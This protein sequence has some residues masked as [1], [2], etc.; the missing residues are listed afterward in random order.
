MQHMVKPYNTFE[1]YK[2]WLATDNNW[3]FYKQAD[4]SFMTPRTEILEVMDIKDGDNILEVGCANGKT[5]KV[6]KD[7]YRVNI[8][9]VEID[10]ELAREA[11]EYGRI[12][13]GSVEDYLALPVIPDF[14]SIIM[15]DVI[16]HLLE[17]WSVVRDLGK[18]LKRGGSIYASIPNYFHATVMFNLFNYGSFCYSSS[19]LINK[20]HLRYFTFRDCV[21]LFRMAGL[22]PKLLGG[23]KLPCKEID[24]PGDSDGVSE[25][26]EM[27]APLGQVFKRPDYYFDMYQ[28]VFKATKE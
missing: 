24:N 11:E 16:E 7:N 2:K 8:Y 26:V 22:V 17:P 28:F 4:F 6:L 10:K 9:G 1:E 15:A 5:L 19:D 14:D 25:L 21:E 18:Y 13:S 23:I 3:A 20:D 12:Y 27:I